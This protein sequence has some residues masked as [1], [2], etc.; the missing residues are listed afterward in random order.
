[1]VGWGNGGGG[2]WCGRVPRG[3]GARLVLPLRG[4]P[5]LTS[6]VVA[7]P[8]RVPPPPLPPPQALGNMLLATVLVAGKTVQRLFLGTLRF[9]EVERLHLRIREA[10]IETCLAMTVFRDDFNTKFCLLFGLLLFLKVFHWLA[11]DRIE[12]VRMGGAGGGGGRPDCARAG[13]R[14]WAGVRV[15]R[16]H[17]PCGAPGCWLGA[18]LQGC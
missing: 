5:Q 4:H 9:R 12:F 11:K 1:M 7:M 2:E 14:V 13:A 3:A 8:P 6:P 17:C 16:L 18:L 10:I 15:L